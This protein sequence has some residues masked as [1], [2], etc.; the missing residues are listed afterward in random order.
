MVNNN[1]RYADDTTLM[2]ESEEE[3][4]SKQSSNSLE[5]GERWL[6]VGTMKRSLVV[7]FM[8]VI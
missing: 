8:D 5:L 2:A 6:N 1:L 3:L 4:K 7:Q